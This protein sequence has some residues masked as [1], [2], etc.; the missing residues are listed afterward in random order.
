MYSYTF[1][2]YFKKL[3]TFLKTNYIPAQKN[4]PV[5]TVYF[6]EE[7]VFALLHP[8]HPEQQVFPFFFCILIIFIT[9]AIRAAT[10]NRITPSAKFILSSYKQTSDLKD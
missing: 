5:K 10:V 2:H 7:Q 8:E 6:A 3:T 1:Y 9:P 4:C